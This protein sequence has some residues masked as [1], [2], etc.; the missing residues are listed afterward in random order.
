MM[1]MRGNKRVKKYPRLIKWLLMGAACLMAAAG[2]AEMIAR[3]LSDRFRPLMVDVDKNTL[4]INQ[5]YFNDFFNYQAP[6]F[7]TTS[8]SN[9][10]IFREKKDR[11]R[12]FCIGESSTSGYPYNTLPQMQCPS[13]FPNYLRAVL[14]YRKQNPSIEI[15]N[16]GCNG[17]KSAN[18]LQ[19]FK[20]LMPFQPDLVILYT[21]HSEY[22]GTDEF[23]VPVRHTERSGCSIFRNSFVF[24]W[25]ARAVFAMP[26][27]RH[28]T[29]MDP[30]DWSLQNTISFEDPVN[31]QVRAA[32]SRNLRQIVELARDANIKLI[33]CAPVSNW[34]F[35]PFI[36]QANEHFTEKR[37]VQWD[38]L[39]HGAKAEFSAGR[40]EHAV[41]MW[42]RL[43]G[44]D[45]TFADL[46]YQTGKARLKLGQYPEAAYELWRAKDLDRLPMRAKSYVSMACR[47]IARSEGVILADME[48]YFIE[49]ADNFYPNPNLFLDHIHPN[50][51][52]YYYMSL[53]L[54]QL[55]LENKLIPGLERLDYPDQKQCWQAL[56]IQDFVVDRIEYDFTAQSSLA[57]ASGLNPE[58]QA[59]LARIKEKAYT[60]A[61][62]VRNE[63]LKES[64]KK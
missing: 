10:A 43:K 57:Q 45:S 46:Y 3:R 29:P 50:D 56:G 62:Q 39:M 55:I 63:M 14:Q 26:Y 27:F 34:T 1:V 35:P 41:E 24:H 44:M 15:L 17:F 38:S 20:D 49:L 19:L 9:R 58:I 54:A 31:Q 22:Y 64:L 11:F 6:L 52:G 48:N 21:G 37:K 28:A 32:Y 40:F 12:I 23:S 2:M 25:L 59:F 61:M 53:Y 4:K 5:A 16:A 60:H 51:S 7:V 36:S 42:Q 30:L 13:S 47:E 8:V 18:V 33:I